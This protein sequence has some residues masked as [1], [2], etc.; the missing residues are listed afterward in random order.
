MINI[1]NICYN[2]LIILYSL[3]VFNKEIDFF[4][5][6]FLALKKIATRASNLKL[7]SQAREPLSVP[8][9]TVA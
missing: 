1:I 3:L 7:D 8:N 4:H 5:S 2:I 9:T 6:L